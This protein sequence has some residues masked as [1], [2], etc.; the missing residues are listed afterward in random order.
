MDQAAPAPTPATMENLGQKKYRCIEC[1]LR[2]AK[3]SLLVPF[4]LYDLHP[5]SIV[6]CQGGKPCDV[7]RKNKCNCVGEED[8][9]HFVDGIGFTEDHMLTTIPA[10]SVKKLGQCM[11]CRQKK[12]RVR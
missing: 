5:L 10:P 4:M 6:Q 9:S 2:K 11:N 12:T 3:A 8:I 7:C 1:M